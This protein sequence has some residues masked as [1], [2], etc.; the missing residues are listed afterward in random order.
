MVWEGAKASYSVAGVRLARRRAKRRKKKGD[1]PV[2][3]FD[4]RKTVDLGTC[5][6][7]GK[8]KERV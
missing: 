7:E 4:A 3:F 2:W 1:V 8:R 6:K 5:L